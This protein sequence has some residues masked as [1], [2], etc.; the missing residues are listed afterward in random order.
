MTQFEY[1]MVMVALILALALAQALRGLSEILTSRDRYWPHTLW[2]VNMIFLIVQA[3]WANWDYN[4]I[5]EWRFT[6]YLLALTSPTITF[7]G[8]YLLVP[9]TRSAN[10]DW[11]DQFY[12]VKQ[13]YF[14]FAIVYVLLAVLVTVVHFGAPLIHSY[15]LFQGLIVAIL[16]VGFVTRNEKVHRVLPL[17]FIA[18]LAASQLLVRMDIGALMAD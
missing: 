17:L 7:A 14:G 15:R 18:V 5:D 13:W 3:W 8:V 16:L 11:R 10:L 4:A 9:A 12:K 1:I 6:T 2:L